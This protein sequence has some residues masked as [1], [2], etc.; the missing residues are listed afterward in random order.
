[1]LCDVGNLISFK[2]EVGNGVNFSLHQI[3]SYVREVERGVAR[4]EKVENASCA[5]F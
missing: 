4:M 2:T 5:E 3:C 1:M